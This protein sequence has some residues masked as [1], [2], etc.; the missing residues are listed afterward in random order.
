MA[1]SKFRRAL[2]HSLKTAEEK[3]IIHEF[4]EM[5]Y[6]ELLQ[7]YAGS[8]NELVIASEA[9]KT[10]LKERP[11]QLDNIKYRLAKIESGQM[12]SGLITPLPAGGGKTEIFTQSLHKM[13]KEVTVDGRVKQITPPTVIIVPSQDLLDQTFN[14]LRE[15]FPNLLMGT[16][17]GTITDIQPLT[18]YIV[19]SF[20][21]DF[22]S[23]FIHQND[24]RFNII[25]EGHRILSADR[26][27][28]FR[29][30]FG[31]AIL[32]TYSAS[33]V[34]T[35]RPIND[36][37]RGL[38]E[39]L[40]EDSII[41][42]PNNRELTDG[43]FLAPCHNIIQKIIVNSEDLPEELRPNDPD[44]R[45]RFHD[46]ITRLKVQ[47]AIE[48]YKSYQ[49]P[50]TGQRAFGKPGIGFSRFVRDAQTAAQMFEEE[51]ER[52]AAE[53]SDAAKVLSAFSDY[54]TIVSRS[55]GDKSVQE[56]LDKVLPLNRIP[57]ERRQTPQPRA[58]IVETASMLREG[59]DADHLKVAFGHKTGPIVDQ[60]QT[61]GRVR[62]ELG[63]VN[64]P[65][66]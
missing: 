57:Q 50:E 58:L 53:D 19:N 52:M 62:R 48:F 60:I 32:D 36:P 29:K 5:S 16:R 2:E 26:A 4:Y 65:Q 47:S 31:I 39:L 20:M 1:N 55:L 27:D 25:D 14:G 23:G 56:A 11:Y 15:K 12:G 63:T 43:E 66:V 17:N 34:F 61:N 51:F 44:N 54:T 38:Y 59:F 9:G 22:Q 40:G 49:D 37:N 28:A 8:L 30:F 18:I 3:R 21:V 33:P 13:V 6:A 10:R 64:K 35:N 42:S 7:Y 45:D 24:V 46:F 41:P